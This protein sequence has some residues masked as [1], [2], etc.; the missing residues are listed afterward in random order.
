MSV[1]CWGLTSYRRGRLSN[2]MWHVPWCHHQRQAPQADGRSWWLIWLHAF[3]FPSPLPIVL[4]QSLFC[5]Q[6]ADWMLV[7]R[8]KNRAYISA[9][10]ALLW[11]IQL[12]EVHSQLFYRVDI[13]LVQSVMKKNTFHLCLPDLLHEPKCPSISREAHAEKGR[14]YERGRREK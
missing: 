7:A 4:L 2:D 3:Y 13:W 5:R 9:Y 11:N 10:K 6:L 8:P 12:G 14:S 1:W